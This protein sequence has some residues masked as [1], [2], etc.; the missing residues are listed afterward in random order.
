MALLGTAIAAVGLVVNE[1][2]DLRS[3][4]TAGGGPIDGRR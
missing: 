3:A 1:I 4:G 2:R